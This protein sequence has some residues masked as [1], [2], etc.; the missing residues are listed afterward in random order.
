MSSWVFASD[1]YSF[2]YVADVSPYLWAVIALS[3]KEKCLRQS[4]RTVDTRV[5]SIPEIWE[6]GPIGYIWPSEPSRRQILGWDMEN[7]SLPSVVKQTE[8][9]HCT[10]LGSRQS[11]F[12][13]ESLCD[14]R[15]GNLTFRRS[16]RSSRIRPPTEA[17]RP[18]KKQNR[19]LLVCC[20]GTRIG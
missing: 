9:W 11:E 13:V 20:V 10:D 2:Q 19:C 5:V 17:R 18:L 1:S 7:M 15:Q 12:Q 16:S 8:I 14:H 6:I 3:E 4:K